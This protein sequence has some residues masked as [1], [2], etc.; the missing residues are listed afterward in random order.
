MATHTASCEATWQAAHSVFTSVRA[1]VK[2]TS[3]AATQLHSTAPRPWQLAR[4]WASLQSFSQTSCWNPFASVTKRRRRTSDGGRGGR[5]GAQPTRCCPER[6]RAPCLSKAV[7]ERN[8]CT[9]AP[10]ELG[11]GPFCRLHRHPR[12]TRSGQTW[13]W[14]PRRR[15]RERKQEERAGARGREGGGGGARARQRET[16]KGRGGGERERERERK[17]E[18]G[19]GQVER[20]GGETRA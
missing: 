1:G 8:T 15:A 10:E 14:W 7:S 5:G 3:R 16:D 19:G 2:R 12:Q 20:V 13:T 11:G 9:C 4:R 6:L 18:R 17:R